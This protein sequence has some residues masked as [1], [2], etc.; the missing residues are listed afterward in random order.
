MLLRRFLGDPEYLFPRFQGINKLFFSK[1]QFAPSVLLRTGQ[2]ERRADDKMVTVERSERRGEGPSGPIRA[3]RRPTVKLALK[4]KK[5]IF[6]LQEIKTQRSTQPDHTRHFLTLSVREVL[7][8]NP[9]KP[10]NHHMQKK[11]L[12]LIL[13]HI[14]IL[15][16]TQYAV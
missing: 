13:K 5:T 3:E 15:R 8:K 16:V 2:E 6:A 11:L 9:Q 12:R 1:N 4:H 10:Q 14:T 7:K